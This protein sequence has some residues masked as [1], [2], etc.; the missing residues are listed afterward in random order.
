M[1]APESEPQQGHSA[2]PSSKRVPL[3]T[4]QVTV[5]LPRELADAARN[6]VIAT[7]P[8]SRGYQV[9]SELVADALQEKLARLEKQFNNGQPFPARKVN[10]RRGR[11]LK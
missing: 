7:T 9:F 5:Y 8:H 1:T 10:L 11:P 6:A 3:D 2:R 4:Q